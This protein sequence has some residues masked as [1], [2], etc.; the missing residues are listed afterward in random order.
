MPVAGAPVVRPAPLPGGPPGA[1]GRAGPPR[2][3]CPPR[4]VPFYLE[5]KAVFL[6][7]LVRTARPP[8]AVQKG[9]AGAAAGPD[10][11]AAGAAGTATVPRREA[12]PAAG[13]ALLWAVP[14]PGGVPAA[15]PACCPRQGGRPGWR[16]RARSWLYEAVLAPAST[17][18]KA[19]LTKV[20]ALEFLVN[21]ATQSDATAAVRARPA[22]R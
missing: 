20:P 21:P 14:R 22:L 6:A 15:S 16:A 7:W 18:L 4:R 1:P 2:A 19:E 13:P 17:R 8:R 12:R 11:R 9:S 10:A 5:A 3:P